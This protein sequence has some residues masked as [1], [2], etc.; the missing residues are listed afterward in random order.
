MTKVISVVSNDVV[1]DNRIQKIAASLQKYGYEVTLLGRKRDGSLVLP[2]IKSSIVRI[3]LWFNKGIL[4]YANLNIRYFFYLLKSE[5]DI[6]ISND[7]DTL[8][9]SFMASKL[10]NKKLFFDSHEL[11]SELPELMAHPLKRKI[12]RKLE[13]IL[14]PQIKA[15]I[16]VSPSIA[17]YY[18]EAYGKKFG[19]VLNT[20]YFNP[21]KPSE[22]QQQEE[23]TV[24][25]RGMVNLGRGLELLID[26][27]KQMKNVKLLIIGDGDIK[28]QLEEKIHKENIKDKII[29]LGRLAI[30]DIENYA[31]KAQVGLSLEEDMGLNYRY[32]LPNKL[33]DYIQA[34]LPVLV[35]D[36][37]EMAALVKKYGVGEVLYERKPE[38]LAKLLDQM[39]NKNISNNKY[40]TNLEMAARE[41]CWEKEEDKLIMEFKKLDA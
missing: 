24:L 5:F 8:P 3:K 20:A 26:A 33:F 1:T 15:G 11:F 12:W 10:S 37:P 40:N 18:S 25:Y 41:F 13:A 2:Q 21:N 29:F 35:S 39:L 32:A 19:I 22:M 23:K 36:L 31:S 4:F 30:N 7:L 34:R 6:I 27:I 16:T 38:T 28:D 17:E 9:A 14:L